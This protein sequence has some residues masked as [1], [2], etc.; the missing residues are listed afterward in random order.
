MTNS[1]TITFRMDHAIRDYLHARAKR[2]NR[3]MNGE[4]SAILRNLM[5]KEKAPGNSLAAT[6]PDASH[7]E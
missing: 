2:F 3:S 5:E 6:S 7:A 4:F 1:A